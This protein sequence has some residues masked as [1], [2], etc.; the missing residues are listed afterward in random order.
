MS[1]LLYPTK[2]PTKWELFLIELGLKENI[3]IVMQLAMKLDNAKNVVQLVSYRL[4]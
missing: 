3:D 4:A 1:T 2:T